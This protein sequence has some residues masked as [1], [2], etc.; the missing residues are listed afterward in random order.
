MTVP[1]LKTSTRRVGPVVVCAFTGDMIMECEEVGARALTRALAERPGMLAVD[2]A[3]VELFTSSALNVLL[4]ARRAAADQGVPLVLVNP[5][6]IVRQVLTLTGATELFPTY[7]TA[8]VAARAHA[9]SA[10]H[11]EPGGGGGG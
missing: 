10:D 1:V 11:G 7:P 6:R 9:R 3:G 4:Q 8:E 2:L 5:N